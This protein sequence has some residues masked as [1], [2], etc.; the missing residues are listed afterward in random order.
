VVIQ[1]CQSFLEEARNSIASTACFITSG[2]LNVEQVAAFF[3]ELAYEFA[4][5]AVSTRRSRAV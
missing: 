4:P 2:F 1:Y 3:A 5:P